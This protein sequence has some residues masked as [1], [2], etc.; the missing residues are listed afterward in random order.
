VF[1]VGSL[2]KLYLE[3][4]NTNQSIRVKSNESAVSSW[5]TDPSEVV[6]GGGLG[7]GGAP[8]RVNRCVATPS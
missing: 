1:S 6:P 4:R 8:V 5:E 3:N 7:G 2:Q